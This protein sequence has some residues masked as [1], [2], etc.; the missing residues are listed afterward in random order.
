MMRPPSPSGTSRGA[1][2]ARLGPEVRQALGEEVAV[3]V[4]EQVVGHPGSGLAPWRR[5]GAVGAKGDDGV[6]CDVMSQEALFDALADA[7]VEAHAPGGRPPV[8]DSTGG[9]VDDRLDG[10]ATVCL[11]QWADGPDPGPAA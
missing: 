3:G 8:A 9:R 7:I 4:D 6:G 11:R 1:A 5:N 2:V 10:L